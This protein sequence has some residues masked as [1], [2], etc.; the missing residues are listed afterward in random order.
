WVFLPILLQDGQRQFGQ[1]VKAQVL[2]VGVLRQIQ[3]GLDDIAVKPLP[4]T[5][6]HLFH[7]RTFSPSP[8]CEK[9]PVAIM[10]CLSRL[11][12]SWFVLDV[13]VV[14]ALLAVTADFIAT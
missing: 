14:L 10:Y 13:L 3:C 1:R 11:D 4:R 6:L 2:D 8:A 5:D 7:R 9:S 12:S